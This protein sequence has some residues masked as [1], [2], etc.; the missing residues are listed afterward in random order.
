[1]NQKEKKGIADKIKKEVGTALLKVALYSRL[2][3]CT[4]CK[5]KNN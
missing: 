5:Q 1:M 4:P 3:N 2:Q